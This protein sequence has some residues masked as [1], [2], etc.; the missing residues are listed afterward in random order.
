MFNFSP[1]P[2]HLVQGEKS[3]QLACTYLLKQGLKLIEKNFSSK[4]GEIDLIM[5]DAETLVIVEVRFR[6]SNKYGGALESISRKKQSRIIVTTQY[7]L[8][9]NKVDSLIRFDVITMSNDSDI[10]W[11]QN[12]FQS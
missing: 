7:Y 11:I 10:N 9:R 5:Q 1:K 2:S 8:S 4:Y 3:E 6:K 12:A